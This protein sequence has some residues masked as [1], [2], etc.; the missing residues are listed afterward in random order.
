[1]QGVN[2]VTYLDSL[3]GKLTKKKQGFTTIVETVKGERGVT[4][5]LQG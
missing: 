2:G 5:D 1:M 4:N 3:R